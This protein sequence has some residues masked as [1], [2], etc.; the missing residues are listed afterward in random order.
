MKKKKYDALNIDFKEQ[1]G[2]WN[3]LIHYS[4][5]SKIHFFIV[6]FLSL[7]SGFSDFLTIALLQPII[8]IFS[9]QNISTENLSEL[10]MYLLNF[11]NTWNND[12]KILGI[13]I[14]LICLQIIREFSLY[15]TEFFNLRIRHNFELDLRNRVYS[16]LLN[17]DFK[18]YKDKD[19]GEIYTLLNSLP[20]SVSSFVFS[21]VSYIPQIII[22]L[23]YLSLMLM[24]DIKFTLI[25]FSI[26]II[27]LLLLKTAY[28]HQ[29]YY[30][31]GM[32]IGLEMIA[33]KANEIIN[34]LPIIQNFRQQKR[35]A[36]KFNLVAE[37]YIRSSIKN[38]TVNAFL[39]P[40]QRIS[41]FLIVIFSIL[42]YWKLGEGESKVIFS[43]IIIF[44][45]ILSKLSGPFT[46]LNL[47]R[48][49]IAQQ[50]PFV[51]RLLKFFEENNSKTRSIKKEISIKNIEKIEFK[52]VSFDYDKKTI[53]SNINFKI[54]NGEQIAI[55]GESG[56]GKSTLVS[57]MNSDLKPKTGKIL[58][59]S[60]NLKSFCRD[61]WQ[62]FVSY[63]SQKSYM[64]N[65][66]LAE[67]VKFGNPKTSNENLEKV[68]KLS[69]AKN[70]VTKLPKKI[71]TIIGEG[72][73]NLSVG[74]VQRLAIA[75]ALI[76]NKPLI[77]LD[78]VTS[79]QDVHSEKKIK[80]TLD[81]L[82]IKKTVVIVSH[83][84]GL[85]KNADRIFVLSE[86]K[87]VENGSH[88]ELIRLD[89]FYKNLYKKY[90][91]K[92]TIAK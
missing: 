66:T 86:G 60:K 78:E 19:S 38:Q 71:H 14:I 84:I 81:N 29:A 46:N 3:S 62:G 18:K 13:L 43:Y 90:L 73:K 59:N 32:R 64:F 37:S 65:F 83:R 42:I 80:H 75:R 17:L 91:K 6:I 15:I 10:Q 72:G 77:I 45:V 8:L 33:S 57:L 25:I 68:L 44:L 40:L 1:V 85:I 9:N 56:S 52:N 2:L 87:L 24:I 82:K 67:N 88:N 30:S 61:Y 53:L 12:Q 69:N 26:S 49:T 47:I 48:S 39:G 28:K 50:T 79:A 36:K 22:I 23:I 55:V 5:I 54:L 4:K 76:V 34:A 51:T 27:I 70:F 89:G 41:T 7:I 63:V 74:Q 92:D 20:R 31:K 35:M 16:T 11:F 21:M 58:I